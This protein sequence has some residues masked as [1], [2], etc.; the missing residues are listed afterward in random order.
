MPVKS[1]QAERSARTRAALLRVARALFAQHGYAGAATDD[2]VRRARVT[3]GALY[4]HFKDK[5]DL[6]KAVYEEEQK[7]IAERANAAAAS[8]PDPWSA[9]VAGTNAM[10]DA[11]VEPAVHRIVMIDAPAVLG[12]EKWRESDQSYYLAAMKAAVRA[13]I[14]QGQIERQPVDPLA[15]L[16]LGAL[17][18]A[19]ML[20]AHA[21]DKTAARREVTAAVRR[22]FEG[23]RA[24][25]HPGS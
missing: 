1:R 21:K 23:L 9:M 7:K 11:C 12:L 2:V 6:F 17:T 3:R 16:I 15:H 10:L 20:I 19:A 8:A 5:Q 4:H 13:A 18:E 25:P 14:D 24:T 22:L